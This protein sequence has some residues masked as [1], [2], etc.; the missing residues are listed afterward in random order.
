[1]SAA[2]GVKMNASVVLSVKTKLAAP[3]E[4]VPLT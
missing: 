4:D 2:F 1:M 3:M